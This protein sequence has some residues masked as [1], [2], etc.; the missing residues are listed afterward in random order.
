[1]KKENTQ[2]NISYSSQTYTFLYYEK[3][4]SKNRIK[5]LLNK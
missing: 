3:Y 4:Q 1:M 2:N 5:K